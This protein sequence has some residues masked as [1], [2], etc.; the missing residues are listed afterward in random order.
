MPLAYNTKMVRRPLWPP[1]AAGS[2]DH[3]AQGRQEAA[4]LTSHVPYDR[5]GSLLVS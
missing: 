3:A 2:P 1:V 4:N 5:I